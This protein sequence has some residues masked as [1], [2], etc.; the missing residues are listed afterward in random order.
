M[1]GAP[2]RGVAEARRDRDLARGLGSRHRGAEPDL[3]HGDR[4][5]RRDG[6][7]RHRRARRAGGARRPHRAARAGRV[8]GRLRPGVEQ[9][10]RRHPLGGLRPDPR[11]PGGGRRPGQR[12][13][14]ARPD[15][16]DR[17]GGAARRGAAAADPGADVA[18]GAAR[19]GGRRAAPR[20]PA[21]GRPGDPAGRRGRAAA[22]RR[23]RGARLPGRGAAHD[24]RRRARPVPGVRRPGDRG[25][26][27]R[28]A[29]EP[30]LDR[31]GALSRRRSL[32]RAAPGRPPGAAR[33]RRA[34]RCRGDHLAGRPAE[35]GRHRVAHGDDVGGRRPGH[36]R[37]QGHERR[38]GQRAA[39]ARS[40]RPDRVGRVGC[41]RGRRPG[42]DLPQ[43]QPRQGLRARDRSG[44]DHA[45]HADRRQRQHRPG[46]QRVLRRQVGQLLPRVGALREHRADP[47]RR[48][49]RVRSLGAHRRDPLGASARSTAR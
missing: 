22:G 49:P 38:A 35:L 11:R 21:G 24:R 2:D 26:P 1:V 41:H 45:R 9:L 18:G 30:V 4:G 32:P 5:A 16:H 39:G 10:R 33:P 42:P 15:V 28:A 43:R 3:G 34:R 37:Q 13:V 25:D 36:G 44:A 8:A 14:Q 19:S 17:L 27:R 46:L 48:L 40:G 6:L 47:G 31:H 23:R 7:G 20:S 12:P 29:D